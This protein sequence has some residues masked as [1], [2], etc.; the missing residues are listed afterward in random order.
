[1]KNTNAGRTVALD[2]DGV[3]NTYTGWKGEEELF[4]PR[5]GLKEFLEALRSVPYRVVV[6]TT[7]NAACVRTWLERYGLFE[8]VDEVTSLKPPA[9][10]YVDDRALLFNGHFEEAFEDITRFKT[11]WEKENERASRLERQSKAGDQGVGEGRPRPK[12]RPTEI[13]PG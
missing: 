2:F 3:M 1:M 8:L 7:R 10:C 6:H 13:Y 9:I 12:D 5:E 4:E 11:H